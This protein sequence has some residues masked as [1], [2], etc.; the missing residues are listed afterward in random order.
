[1]NRLSELVKKYALVSGV[2]AEISPHTM[3][4]SFATHALAGGADLRQVQDMWGHVSTGQLR[5]FFQ[6]FSPENG[7]REGAAHS[8]IR[9]FMGSR[10]QTL[11]PANHQIGT[12]TEGFGRVF[13]VNVGEY[14]ALT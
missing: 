10:D 3:R 13:G 12:P 8:P 6:P 4:H 5:Y 2:S 1:M 9:L 7:T 11:A 14:P